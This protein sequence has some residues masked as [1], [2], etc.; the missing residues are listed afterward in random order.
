M[1]MPK[2]E[3]IMKAYEATKSFCNKELYPLFADEAE[4]L[5][6][7]RLDI[8]ATLGTTLAAFENGTAKIEPEKKPDVDDERRPTQEGGPEAVKKLVE[9]IGHYVFETLQDSRTSMAEDKTI[10]LLLTCSLA[11]AFDI[12]KDVAELLTV[13]I[14][15]LFGGDKK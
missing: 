3:T 11:A 10:I 15:K 13:G 9:E 4:D 7:L 8:M 2:H 14:S 1:K 6:D 5:E 12:E